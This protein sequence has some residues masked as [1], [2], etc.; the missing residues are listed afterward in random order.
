MPELAARPGGEVVAA[1]EL[2]EGRG[3][4]LDGSPLDDGKP[5]QVGHRAHLPRV[6]PLAHEQVAVVR[7]RLRRVPRGAPNAGVSRRLHLIAAP[8]MRPALAGQARDDRQRP[9]GPRQ[10]SR[11]GRILSDGVADPT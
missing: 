1:D 10:D 6:D 8:V 7:H 11:H 2:A 4:R 9:P 3:R 5:A